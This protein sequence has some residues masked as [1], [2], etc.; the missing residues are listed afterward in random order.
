[1]TNKVNLD[2][3][4]QAG[5][6]KPGIAIDQE[7]VPTPSH[8]KGLHLEEDQHLIPGGLGDHIQLTGNHLIAGEDLHL[9]LHTG[10]LD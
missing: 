4:L 6:A 5:K 8:R 9:I 7:A 1:M 2:P 3:D 10:S